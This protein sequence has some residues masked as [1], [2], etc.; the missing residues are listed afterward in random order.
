MPGTPAPVCGTDTPQPQEWGPWAAGGQRSP[1]ELCERRGTVAVE[2]LP[3]WG[4]RGPRG[5]GQLW[6]PRPSSHTACSRHQP[7]DERTVCPA[8][9]SEGALSRWSGRGRGLTLAVCP[10]GELRAVPRSRVRTSGGSE[11]QEQDQGAACMQ[12]SASQR[13]GPYTGIRKDNKS[14][15]DTDAR[16]GQARPGQD[17]MD[18]S[19]AAEWPWKPLHVW[20]RAGGGFEVQKRESP[21][22]DPKSRAASEDP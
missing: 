10:L 3:L 5:R 12:L 9:V 13:A 21:R 14:S 19:R 2:S 16:P 6:A 4:L 17:S 11:L 1:R 8:V 20:G 7:V 18:N 15:Y 22:E